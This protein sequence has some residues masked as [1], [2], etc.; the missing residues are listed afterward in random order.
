MDHLPIFVELE[1]R[2]CLVVGGGAVAERKVRELLEAG[3]VVT[4][5]SPTVT[6]GLEQLVDASTIQ[7]QPE[8]FQENQLGEYWL[9]VAATAD[10]ELNSRI[11][12]A[13]ESQQC[14]CN[15]VDDA[16]LCSFIMP[17]VVKRAP[18]TVA[19][20][21]SGRSP[22]LARW[23]KGLIESLLPTRLGSLASLAGRCRDL[24]RPDKPRQSC[25]R[26]LRASRR[27]P[28]RWQPRPVARRP[29]STVRVRAL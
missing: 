12:R 8:T 7:L 6:A 24:N 23:V 13:A 11:A 15:V 29:S 19:V 20:S 17:A 18:I 28:A 16:E 3:A 22:V 1:G 2:P 4:I 21:S 27:A 10:R 5:V 14:F 9:V 26:R 25:G